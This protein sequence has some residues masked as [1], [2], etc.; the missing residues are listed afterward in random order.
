[1]GSYEAAARARGLLDDDE[2]YMKCIGEAA[3]FQNPVHLRDL[4]A[5]VLTQC[6][7][8]DPRAIYDKYLK[9]PLSTV[10]G[11]ALTEDY[12]YESVKA[13][14]PATLTDALTRRFLRDLNVALQSFGKSLAHFPSLPQ[15]APGE[16]TDPHDAPFVIDAVELEQRVSF[17]SFKKLFHCNLAPA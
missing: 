8:A 2:E 9:V 16:D 10:T 1:M 12:I 6:L 13:G 14:G 15:L 7:P 4:Y 5:C 3:A 11:Q 17:F